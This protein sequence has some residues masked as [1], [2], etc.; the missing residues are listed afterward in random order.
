MNTNDFKLNRETLSMAQTIL[1]ASCEQA[2]E[3]DFLLPDYYPDIFRILKCVIRP[4]VSSHSINGGKL[5]F[6]LTALIRVLYISENDRRINCIEQKMTYTKSLDIQGECID[7]MIE[8]TPKCDY[9]NCRVVNQRRLDIRGAVSISAKVVGEVSKPIVTDAFG[10]GIQLKKTPFTYTAKRLTALK[11]ITVIE[12]LALA[13]SKP[14]VGTILRTSCRVIPQDHKMIAGKLVTKGD[15]E[16]SMLYGCV[17]P[18]GEESAETMRFTVPFSQ[19]IDIDGIDESFTAKVD[20]TAAGCEMIPRGEDSSTLECEI[21]LIV[22]CV[23]K[24]LASC[25]IVTDAYSTCFECEGESYESELECGSV[26]ISENHSAAAKLACQEG[27]LKCV[28]DS[29][30]AVSDIN[31]RFDEDKNAFV[32]SGNVNFCL[33]GRNGDG[34]PVYLESDMPFEHEVA[35]PEGCTREAAF[36]PKVTVESCS[37]YLADESSAEVKAEIKIEGELIT[38]QVGKMLTDLKVLFDKPKE[39]NDRYALKICYCTE[40]DDIWEIA[41]KYSTSVTAI[42]EEN[43]LADDKLS[44]QGMLLIPL[45]N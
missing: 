39:K 14:P 20:I 23:A 38:K 42:L 11:R 15:V 41:K 30:A 40:N 13:A 43:E 37:Y 26:K 2:V 24:K 27:E 7:P 25:E 12:E 18:E 34:V 10:C 16:I 3:K 21:V 33:L 9:V 19:I 17:T 4:T 31:T 35:L 45:M 1:D 6:E 32:V 22:S 5:S 44:R 8:L 28:H 29:W 36:C